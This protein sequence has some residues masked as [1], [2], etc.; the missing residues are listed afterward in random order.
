M[1]HRRRPPPSYLNLTR[2]SKK[3][4]AYSASVA[5]Y[6]FAENGKIYV[7]VNLACL[8]IT[9]LWL[10]TR[11]A[12]RA[13]GDDMC[14]VARENKESFAAR[15]YE[16]KHR[17]CGIELSCKLMESKYSRA[18][19]NSAKSRIVILTTYMSKVSAMKIVSQ[20][21]T[22][23]IRYR[24]R[25]CIERRRDYSAC[26]LLVVVSSRRI[27]LDVI[28]VCVDEF[29]LAQSFKEDDTG[30]YKP[31]ALCD[32]DEITLVVMKAETA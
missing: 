1:Y 5:V 20:N 9:E 4:T 31:L 26:T 7:L 8:S 6:L 22:V 13:C 27:S 3:A 25:N 24:T 10:Y 14:T 16:H 2:S 28:L 29:S 12:L 17:C 30:S 23:R 19:L 11:S 18:T 32:R 21:S 15:L